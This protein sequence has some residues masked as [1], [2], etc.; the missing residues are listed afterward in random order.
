MPIYNL[1]ATTK[2]KKKKE[3]PL[4]SFSQVRL[5]DC[6]GGGVSSAGH[7]ATCPLQHI[8][9]EGTKGQFHRAVF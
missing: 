9:T 3:K 2:K 4:Q 5:A 7:S 1:N 6:L 8:H